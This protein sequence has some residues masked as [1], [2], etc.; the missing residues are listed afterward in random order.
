MPFHQIVPSPSTALGKSTSLHVLYEGPSI[1]DV[2]PFQGGRGVSDYD[3]VRYDPP[4]GHRKFDVEKFC[5][6]ILNFLKNF[7]IFY[8]QLL[9]FFQKCAKVV[10]SFEITVKVFFS[11]FANFPFKCVHA[12]NKPTYSHASTIRSV[13]FLTESH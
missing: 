5:R 9:I 1:K 4:G 6:N 7:D 3:I 11:N 2:G 13:C 12:T 8:G 10:C